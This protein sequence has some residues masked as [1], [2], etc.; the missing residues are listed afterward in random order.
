MEY[1]QLTTLWQQFITHKINENQNELSFDACKFFQNARVDFMDIESLDYLEYGEIVVRYFDLIVGEEE[2]EIR[3]VDSADERFQPQWGFF[4]KDKKK[5]FDQW[6]QKRF[7]LEE[8][9]V[10][11]FLSWT[12]TFL[13]A[14]LKKQAN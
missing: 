8:N 9:E 1:E 11:D 14:V 3:L 4:G 6:L 2:V 5:H 7:G 13:R 10:A 12:N